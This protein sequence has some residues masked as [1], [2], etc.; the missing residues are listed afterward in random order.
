MGTDT[1]ETYRRKRRFARTP[2]LPGSLKKS[3]KKK[4]PPKRRFVIRKHKAAR[5]HFDLRLEAEE[6][7]KEALAKLKQAPQPKWVSPMLA[8]LMEKEKIPSKGWLFEPKL[9]GERCLA[10]KRKGSVILFSRNRKELNGNYP[11]LVEAILAQPADN[12]IG[13]GE[14]VAFD[15]GLPSFS[16]LQPRMQIRDPV[17]SLRTGIEVFLY[18]FDL[19]YFDGYDLG[20]LELR[21]R[22]GMLRQ[23][24]SFGGKVRFLDHVEEDGRGYFKKM[25]RE[26]YEGIIAKRAGSRYTGGRTREWRKFKCTNEQEFVICGYTEP[27]GSRIGFGSLLLGYYE[28]G[29]LVYAGKVGTGYDEFTLKNLSGQMEKLEEKVPPYQDYASNKLIPR[30]GVHWLRPELVCEV[31]FSEWTPEGLLRHPS[32]KGLRADKTPREV[33]RERPA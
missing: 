3:A 16:R 23:I 29:K 12:F 19:I 11:E 7:L 21:Y 26:G 9:D 33:T 6:A 30:T 22:K 8:M 5:L 2:E 25:C 28:G 14:V 17:A 15:K 31:A 27:G 4:A 24:F 18:L 10:M 32:F 1:L 13:D 20:R